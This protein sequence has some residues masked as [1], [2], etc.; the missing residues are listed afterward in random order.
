MK[1]D[2]R[3]YVKFWKLTSEISLSFQIISV[4]L[5]LPLFSF[6]QWKDKCASYSFTTKKLTHS[7][8]QVSLVFKYTV[9]L[10][11][12]WCRLLRVGKVEKVVVAVLDSMSA[13]DFEQNDDHFPTLSAF[14]LVS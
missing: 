14:D 11:F 8:C 4:H 6:T 12:R 13:D 5:S 1:I 9:D 10:F 2:F 3:G 7:M